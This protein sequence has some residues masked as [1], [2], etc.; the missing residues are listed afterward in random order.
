MSSA[1]VVEPV[2]AKTQELRIPRSIELAKIEVCRLP[3]R[4]REDVLAG[5]ILRLLSPGGQTD[6]AGPVIWP[7]CGQ[8]GTR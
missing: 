4:G 3:P 1:K 5:N 2:V 8:A 7:A 6:A